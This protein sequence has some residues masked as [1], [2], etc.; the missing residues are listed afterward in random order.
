M[1]IFLDIFLELLFNLAIKA[2]KDL[3]FLLDVQFDILMVLLVDVG[4]PFLG[5]WERLLTRETRLHPLNHSHKL[6]E[7]H[8]TDHLGEFKLSHCHCFLGRHGNKD[9][10]IAVMKNSYAI[11]FENSDLNLPLCHLI[12]DLVVSLI[13]IS[14][15][16]LDLGLFLWH[17]FL[18][19]ICPLYQCPLKFCLGI[20]LHHV[21]G[22]VIYCLFLTDFMWVVYNHVVFHIEFAHVQCNV[23]ILVQC[24]FQFLPDFILQEVVYWVVEQILPLNTLFRV[25]CYHFPYDIFHNWRD[26]VD[27]FRND[28]WFVLDVGDQVNHVSSRIRRSEYHII[29]FP[30]SN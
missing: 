18:P 14:R 6:F 24:L 1:I 29:Y 22:I 17:I 28:Q 10:D 20:S 21:Q 12:V 11:F 19:G 2:T 3:I 7:E 4:L 8:V 16:R 9:V 27:L 26:V 23:L 5:A 25:D 15:N 13:S 30:K